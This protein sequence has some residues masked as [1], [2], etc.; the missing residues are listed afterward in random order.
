V[1][2]PS[3][4]LPGR[5]V[6]F[7]GNDQSPDANEMSTLHQLCEKC[8]DFR[9]WLKPIW[10]Q[11][12]L[13]T[14][15]VSEHYVLAP[16]SSLQITADKGCHFC[17]I[18]LGGWLLGMGP[19]RYHLMSDEFIAAMTDDLMAVI[20]ID[21]FGSFGGNLGIGAL[22]KERGVVPS[23][24]RNFDIAQRNNNVYHLF[25]LGVQCRRSGSSCMTSIR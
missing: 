19:K 14:S 16:F 21:P 15:Y 25:L 24:S 12:R 23:H 7:D 10:E 17:S 1:V 13:N 3:T 6:P 18:L 8:K 2:P 5:F 22:Y 11:N 20:H 4:Y 9:S